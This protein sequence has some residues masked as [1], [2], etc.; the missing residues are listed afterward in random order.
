[1]NNLW[2]TPVISISKVV[3]NLMMEQGNSNQNHYAD[4]LVRAF[5]VF[6]DLL[7]DTIWSVRYK[8]IN[9]DKTDN[10]IILPE[11]LNLLINI[12]VVNHCGDLVPL[13]SNPK[14]NTL[15]LL[16]APKSCSCSGC[17]G[18]GTLCDALDAIT[19]VDE[20]VMI[21]GYPFTIKT[22]IQKCDDGL[23]RKVIERPYPVLPYPVDSA[24]E[25]TIKTEYETLCT[26]EV[27]SKNC[28]KKTE[29]NHRLLLHHCG[30]YIPGW[31]SQMCG[32]YAGAFNPLSPAMNLTDINPNGINANWIKEYY[33]ENNY[34]PKSD[35]G[36]WN[37]AANARDKIF[38][39]MIRTDKVIICYQTSGD[40]CS[41]QEIVLPEYALDAMMYGIIWRQTAFSPIFSR[42]DKQFAESNYIKK[43]DELRAYL[44]PVA[45]EALLQ[46]QDIIPK[47]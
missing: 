46:L 33:C 26:L 23:I 20:T 24:P 42:S 30:C 29:A 22:W 1:M 32:Y 11:D 19:A 28:I 44:S 40:D 31:Q 34:F 35:Y 25:V 8:V 3:K 12:N 4:N 21:N 36:Y 13:A 18:D 14:M 17:K 6:K 10:S 5:R 15:S 27:T 7:N 41:G 9:V 39:K 16:C 37:W 47:W 45:P 43:K 2:G 38:L